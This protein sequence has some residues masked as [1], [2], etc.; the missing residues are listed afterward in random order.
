MGH[1][2]G[3]DHGTERSGIDGRIVGRYTLYR[4]RVTY[5]VNININI[6]VIVIAD[7]L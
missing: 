2:Y 5:T 3:K 7:C 1:A 6:Y 4:A